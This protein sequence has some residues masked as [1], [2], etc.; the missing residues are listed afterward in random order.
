MPKVIAVA[1]VEDAAKWEEGFRTHAALFASQTVNRPI[2]Y[3]VTEEN[4]IVICFEPDDLETYLEVMASPAT[5]EAMAFDGVLRE[6]VKVHVLD[7]EFDP[8]G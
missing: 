1:Q 3:T 8:T 6:T 7:K 5:A 4:Q 2:R